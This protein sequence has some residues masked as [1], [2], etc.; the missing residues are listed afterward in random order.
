M[1]LLTGAAGFIGSTLAKRWGDNGLSGPFALDLLM[2]DQPEHFR[3]R[4]Y[5]IPSEPTAMDF[6]AGRMPSQRHLVIDREYLPQILEKLSADGTKK[7][8][9]EVRALPENVKIEWVVHIGACTD[10]GQTDVNYLN[11]WNVEYTKSIWR[12]CAEQ[13]L[14][15]VYA[16]SGATYGNGENGFSD[17]HEKTGI[18]A[19]LN[20]YGKSKHE[21]DLWALEEVKKGN[22]SPPHWYGLKF[23]NVYGPNEFH[24]G[25]MASA[26]LHSFRQI[27]SSGR[28]KLFRSHKE[29][30]ADGEQKRDFIY[31]D[32]ICKIIE[33]LISKKPESGLYNCGTGQARSF[34]DLAKAVFAAL[35]LKEKI[36]WIDTPEKYRAAYQ[37]FT[38]A[39]M[40]KL[41]AVGYREPFVDLESGVGQYV[42]FLVATETGGE[43]QM[44][45]QLVH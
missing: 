31:V 23:F 45:S 13:R 25:Q 20:A 27:Q 33:F 32:D 39:K 14:P 21:F 28:C 36:D 37:Y 18:L 3:K 1:V 15:L 2:V 44:P 38:E 29:G 19:P 26:V 6:A 22:P 7:A 42:D 9:P 41:K 30:V 24:K 12:W 4:R 35:G 40:D 5:F 17:D 43:S 34:L 16:S 8:E 10:T 11:K